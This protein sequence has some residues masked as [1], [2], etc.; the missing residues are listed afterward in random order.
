MT[1]C[2]AKVTATVSSRKPI[3]LLELFFEE[4]LA[5][6]ASPGQAKTLRVV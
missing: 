2:C 1:L 4:I 5:N 6:Q 3:Y